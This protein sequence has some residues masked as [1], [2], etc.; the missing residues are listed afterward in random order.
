MATRPDPHGY[1][2]R[3]LRREEAARWVGVSPSKFD[4]LVKNGRIS[5]PKLIDSCVVWDRYRLDV[6]FD[7]LPD[8]EP[9]SAAGDDWRAAV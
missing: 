9:K 3:G 4:E 2:P 1:P 6:D 5:S 7:A 8:R